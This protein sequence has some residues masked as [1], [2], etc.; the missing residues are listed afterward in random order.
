VREDLTSVLADPLERGV[1]GRVELTPAEL[2]GEEEIAPSEPAELGK[3]TA[4]AE[5]IR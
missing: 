2:L 4:V 1:D 5:R 3:L